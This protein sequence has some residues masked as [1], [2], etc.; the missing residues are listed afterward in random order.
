MLYYAVLGETTGNDE[1][2]DGDVARLSDEV[3]FG[4]GSDN[5]GLHSKPH[6]LVSNNHEDGSGGRTHLLLS[7]H[8]RP[9]KH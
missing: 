2:S 3:D 8:T 5:Q 6:N 9:C 7:S 4:S 1:G